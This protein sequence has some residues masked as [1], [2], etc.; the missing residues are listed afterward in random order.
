MLVAAFLFSLSRDTN[1]AS[2]LSNPILREELSSPSRQALSSR[3]ELASG[4]SGGNVVLKPN[5]TYGVNFNVLKLTDTS[6]NNEPLA[7]SNESRSVLVSAFYPSAPADKCKPHL[8]DYVPAAA[9]P[10]FDALGTT[11]G[12]PNGTFGRIRLATCADEPHVTARIHE[13]P[14][15]IF[16]P[17][18]GAS[19]LVYSTFAQQLASQGH[20]VVTIDHPY[21]SVIVQFP[22]GGVVRGIPLPSTTDPNVLNEFATPFVAVRAKDASFVLDQLARPEI[23]REL[24]PCARGPLKTEHAVIFGHSLGGA[25]AGAVLLNDAR[26]RGG[27][28]IDGNFY[29]GFRAAPRPVAIMGSAIH[30]QS[31][32]ATWATFWREQ[33]AW[34]LE[35]TVERTQHLSFTDFPLILQQAGLKL[36]GA[37]RFIGTIEGDRLLHDVVTYVAAFIDFVLKGAAPAVLQGPA[38]D[39]P[40]VL[41]NVTGANG[42]APTSALPV[43]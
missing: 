20:L 7:H 2:A 39:F 6:R 14:L 10:L 38:A 19:R 32:D 11:F 23:V 15:V 4:T 9:V 17:G 34:K 33:A 43:A 21:D 13:L 42:T 24:L 35:L 18:F 41:F 22:D 5:G 25:T 37:E 30:N 1:T 28:N 16:S 3:A 29:G 27:F 8:A 31:N 12:I 40:D 36:P 26:F